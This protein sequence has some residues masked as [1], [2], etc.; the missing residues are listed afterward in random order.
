MGDT[1]SRQGS[2]FRAW[3]KGSS[4]NFTDAVVDTEDYKLE[5]HLFQEACTILLERLVEFIKDFQDE[6]LS[7]QSVFMDKA[8]S[9]LIL[10]MGKNQSVSFLS[11]LFATLA[12]LVWEF[13]RFACSY[14][15]K[16]WQTP[17]PVS[18]LNLW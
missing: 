7:R 5:R 12:I 13:R 15:A 17:F 3:T 8:F 11:S 9:L 6:M 14:S 16:Y 4:K 1:R 2:E 10:L 18:K